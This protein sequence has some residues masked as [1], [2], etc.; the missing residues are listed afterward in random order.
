VSVLT[1]RQKKGVGTHSLTEKSANTHSLTEKGVGTRS[2][3]EKSAGT[4]SFTTGA[5]EN[6]P[7]LCIKK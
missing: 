2:L 7:C 5:V 4:H 6:V 3:T 1:H